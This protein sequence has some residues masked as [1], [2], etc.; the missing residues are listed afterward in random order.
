MA[1]LRQIPF[2]LLILVLTN[3]TEPV[4]Q[5]VPGNCEVADELYQ[6]SIS[7]YE[8]QRF[9]SSASNLVKAY[10]LYLQANHLEKASIACL[11]LGELFNEINKLDSAK[12]YLAKGI[13]HTNHVT[14]LDSIHGRLLT[15][16]A[17]SYIF[18]GNI[19]QA[20]VFYL[21]AFKATQKSGDDEAFLINCS[22]LGVGYRRANQPD[23]A[24]YYYQKGLEV[25]L[26]SKNYDAM[27]NLHDNIAVMFGNAKRIEEAKEH[28]LRAISFAQKGSDSS[29]LIQAYFI[30][31]SLLT[32]NNEHTQAIVMLQKAYQAASSEPSPRLKVK[33]LSALLPALAATNQ[34]DSLHYYLSVSDKY[35]GE[36]PE[37]SNEVIGIYETKAALL[38][39]EKKY[40]ESLEIFQKLAALRSINSATPA[41][42]WYSRIAECYQNMHE[43]DKAYS[44]IKYASELRDSFD[45]EERA[46][47]M[48]ELQIRYKTQEKELEIKK[49][50]EIQQEEKVKNL[51]R[52]I[53]LTTLI[54]LMTLVVIILLYKR[55]LQEEKSERLA[56]AMIRQEQETELR[57]SRK[58]IDGMESERT[59]L[60]RELH[61]GV[62][63]ELLALEIGINAE[64]GQ[65]QKNKDRL[66]ANLEKTRNNI[67][68]ISHA[69]MPP[70]FSYATID[71]IIKD[72]VNHLNIPDS[73]D[74]SCNIS[75]SDWSE[76]SQEV[77]YELY[78]IV[79]EGV[80]NILKHSSATQASISLG[81]DDSCI[82]LE[83][84]NNG[85]LKHTISKGIGMRTMKERINSINGTFHFTTDASGV[86]IVITTPIR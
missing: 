64:Q 43:S 56:Q 52:T 34:T 25:A 5:K 37:A 82:H 49:L 31:G 23:S 70:V 73:M 80:N 61:D 36:L 4:F 83:I 14:S 42:V 74:L 32:S 40:K 44:Y 20:I 69:L 1:I 2:L 38:Q 19:R 12:L 47:Q 76:I 79:Q 22:S 18:E 3:C 30:Y 21:A 45:R 33:I 81:M 41:H 66:L 46:K 50:Q 62:C 60:A 71:E 51:Q 29:D 72:Y 27:A 17:G 58:Y 8:N 7:D 78:R 13:E 59:R 6:K 85:V 84:Y 53:W 57:L 39:K 28:A 48:S 63:N 55:K 24:L 75:P 9:D 11:S 86:R 54:S 35:I 65:E 16:L 77:G 26:K 68:Q 15:N 67:R 10:H